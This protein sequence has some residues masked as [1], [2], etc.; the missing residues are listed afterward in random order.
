M[1]IYL[2]G[3]NS[4]A[5]KEHVIPHSVVETLSSTDH[6]FLLGLLLRHSLLLFFV[7]VLLQDL[8]D[9]IDV[10]SATLRQRYDSLKG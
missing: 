3:G 10:G 1:Y 2:V 8:H 4:R 5:S 9:G 7:F 6:L